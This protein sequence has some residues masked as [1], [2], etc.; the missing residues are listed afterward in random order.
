MNFNRRLRNLE[1]R[2]CRHPIAKPQFGDLSE[3]DE[4]IRMNLCL[5]LPWRH[6]PEE[7]EHALALMKAA[8]RYPI[9]DQSGWLAVREFAWCLHRK[10]GSVPCWGW[11]DD[12]SIGGD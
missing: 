11:P 3:R 1:N 9:D 12:E 10:Y 8:Q 7:F 5:P 2:P 6:T 4:S